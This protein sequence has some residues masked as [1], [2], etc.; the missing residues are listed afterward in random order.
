MSYLED[1]EHVAEQNSLRVNER[2]HHGK[3]GWALPPNIER[4]SAARE[5]IAISVPQQTIEPAP[6][7]TP[8]FQAAEVS[9]YRE[10]IASLRDR[11]GDLGVRYL[12]FDKLACWAEGMTGKAFGSSQMK[13]C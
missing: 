4:A 2:S 10:L 11:V 5:T 6:V 3:L 12:D 7:A 13:R 9:C 8:Q 1:L